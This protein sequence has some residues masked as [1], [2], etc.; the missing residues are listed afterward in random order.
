MDVDT[1]TPTHSENRV[2]GIPYAVFF[3]KPNLTHVEIPRPAI[4]TNANPVNLKDYRFY[5][6]MDAEIIITGVCEW[7]ATTETKTYFGLV[8]AEQGPKAEQEAFKKMAKDLYDIIDVWQEDPKVPYEHRWAWPEGGRRQAMVIID[9]GAEVLQVELTSERSP[10]KLTRQ[11]FREYDSLNMGW[12]PEHGNTPSTVIS[13]DAVLRCKAKLGVAHGEGNEIQRWIMRACHIARC[14]KRR[15]SWAAL[16]QQ[17]H[18]NGI[19]PQR[20]IIDLTE[21][22]ASRPSRRRMRRQR[23]VIDLTGDEESTANTQAVISE[24]AQMA[25]R[26]DEEMST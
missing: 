4:G 19:R 20:E 6:A 24:A 22:D 7:V 8:C 5:P 2:P 16:V 25:E 18:G 11:E 26:D 21:V 14:Y 9:V 13:P 17:A 23:Q 15:S 3:F 10:C 12:V 1:E